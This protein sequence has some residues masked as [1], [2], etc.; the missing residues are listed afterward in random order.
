MRRT[1]ALIIA[2]VAAASFGGPAA[3]NT[4]DAHAEAAK[5]K[6]HKSYR[7]RCRRPNASDYDC[8]GGSGNG[9]LY[10]GRVEV[11]G[12]DHYELD[13]DGDGVGCE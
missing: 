4:G 6:C 1:S 3:A 10:T 7:G 9:P 12:E 11:E 13:R 8:R 5:R 2:T